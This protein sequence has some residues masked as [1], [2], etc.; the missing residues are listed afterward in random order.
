MAAAVEAAEKFTEKPLVWATTQFISGGMLGDKV[1]IEVEQLGGGRT[2]SQVRVV[3]SVGDRLLQHTTAALGGRE[4]LRE[5]QFVKMPDVR[6][7]QNCSFREDNPFDKDDDLAS[8]FE[9]R[10]AFECEVTG[11][12]HMWVRPTGNVAIQASMLG[13]TSD[14]I[15]GAHE[16]HRGNH[17]AAKSLDNTLR[18]YAIQPTEWILCVSHISGFV[19]GVAHGVM[20]QFAEDGT[21]LATSSQTGLLPRMNSMKNSG[22]H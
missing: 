14:F 17:R 7:P 3:N 22:D 1:K 9:R 8:R 10:S 11:V 12:E 18:I 4:E 20:Y 6:A 13:I 19:N 5:H 21:L 15:L 2:I 16:M